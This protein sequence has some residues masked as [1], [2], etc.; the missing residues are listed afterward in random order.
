MITC[1]TEAGRRGEVAAPQPCQKVCEKADRQQHCQSGADDWW[2]GLLERGTAAIGS[3]EGR[4]ELGHGQE[5]T[6][7]QGTV[8]V[9]PAPKIQPQ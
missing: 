2:R 4:R 1:W 5:Q 8:C 9:Y 6:P 7:S 3:V